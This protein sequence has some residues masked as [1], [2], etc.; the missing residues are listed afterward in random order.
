MRTYRDAKR[1]VFFFVINKKSLADIFNR[2]IT[3]AF[4][5]KISKNLGKIKMLV[6]L[7][8]IRAANAAHLFFIML[9]TFS[10]KTLKASSK[11][12]MPKTACSMGQRPVLPRFLI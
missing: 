8:K 10:R 5:A 1:R 4:G 11:L 6:L 12:D 2:E 3:G 7:I 9:F